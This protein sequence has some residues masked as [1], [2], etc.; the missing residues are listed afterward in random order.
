MTP[1]AREDAIQSAR[2]HLRTGTLLSDEAVRAICEAL[3]VDEVKR[4]RPSGERPEQRHTPECLTAQFDP[5][6]VCACK[7]WN[8]GEG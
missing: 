5:G 1:E 8:G 3:L 4:L 6:A 2:L 7:P